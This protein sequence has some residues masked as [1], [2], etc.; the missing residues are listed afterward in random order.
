MLLSLLLYQRLVLSKVGTTAFQELPKAKCETNVQSKFARR[1]SSSFC[2][3]AS[4]SDQRFACMRLAATRYREKMSCSSLLGA[5][6]RR[7]RFMQEESKGAGIQNNEST[8]RGVVCA[9]CRS[10]LVPA[11]DR[12][13]CRADAATPPVQQKC[14]YVVGGKLPTWWCVSA[15]RQQSRLSVPFCDCHQHHVFGEGRG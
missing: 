10:P 15:N 4:D 1:A 8:N 6:M 12:F 5:V 9:L 7:S 14:A 13:A 11:H 2:R 3:V